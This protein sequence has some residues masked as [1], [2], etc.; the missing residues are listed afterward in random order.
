[1]NDP[2]FLFY[3]S[4]FLVGTMFMSD[5]Q[6]GQYIKLMCT[7]HQKGHLNEKDMLKICPTLDED[8]IVKFKKDDKGFYY[9]ERL[10]NEIKKRKA[11]SESR[12]N[13]RLSSTTKPKNIKKD[14]NN[15]CQTHV[16]HMENENVNENI[17]KDIDNKDE[18]KIKK[19]WL[20]KASSL[21]K[22]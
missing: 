20:D 22:K 15:I 3:S 21:F 7:Q 2:A 8:V 10:E 9:N 18:E 5:A 14:M 11:Y 12:R 1:M 13:N 6:V 16:E 4:D 19:E 17:N